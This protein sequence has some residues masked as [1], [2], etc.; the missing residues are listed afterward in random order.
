MRVAGISNSVNHLDNRALMGTNLLELQ[1]QQQ[2]GDIHQRVLAILCVVLGVPAVE[3]CLQCQQGVA[4]RSST[5]QPKRVS[6]CNKSWAP[7]TC[8]A[9]NMV[10]SVPASA[11]AVVT[12]IGFAYQLAVYDR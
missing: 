6:N 7:S 4:W 3:L 8:Q 9:V 5:R 10:V 12:R 1:C 11:G 2:H